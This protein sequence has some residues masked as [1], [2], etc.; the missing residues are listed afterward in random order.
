MFIVRNQ[1]TSQVAIL[2]CS[3]AAAD[4][5][6]FSKISPENTSGRVLLLPKLQTDC[7]EQLLYIKMAPPRKGI[8]L[9]IFLL[10]CSQAAAHSH[11]FLK[12][13]PENTGGRGC[14]LVKLQTG[15]SD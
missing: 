1:I 9:E 8:F 5:H 10:D 7:S 14:L 12:I 11:P 2:E 6:P 13:S 3:E 4:S 15:C